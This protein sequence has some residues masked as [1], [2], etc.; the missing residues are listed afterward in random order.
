MKYYRLLKLIGNGFRLALFALAAIGAVL[1]IKWPS[2]I[3]SINKYNDKIIKLYEKTHRTSFLKASELQQDRPLAAIE[4]YES[5]LKEVALVD[6]GDRLY[7][8]KRKALRNL[9]SLLNAT[10]QPEKALYWARLWVE[11]DDLDIYAQVQLGQALHKT[12]ETKAQ[13]VQLLASLF[14]RFPESKLI[15]EAYASILLD[16]RETAAAFDVLI[17][18]HRLQTA[19]NFI[20]FGWEV[21]WGFGDGFVAAN[22]KQVWA[23][24]STSTSAVVTFKMN[25]PIQATEYRVD[26]PASMGIVILNPSL[27][28]Y[29]NHQQ[30][31]STAIW[32]QSLVLKQMVLNNNA[33][34]AD[35]GA[36][37]FF[38]WELPADFR[39]TGDQLVFKAELQHL[40]SDI[41][42]KLLASEQG[43]DIEQN[44]L[45]S[46]DSKTLALLRDLRTQGASGDQANQ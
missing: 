17:K 45:H 16:D 34:I 2:S 37:P 31:R 22:R 42:V 13:A 4:A 15:A 7:P 12:K 46:G 23:K 29:R 11:M 28:V 19:Q 33:L 9:L 10:K 6:K 5:F 8:L 38:A 1:L 27:Q 35:G 32:E 26:V 30:I 43:A 25:V 39:T 14:Q 36:D 21:F 24:I 18:N 41:L 20:R 3:Q 40:P 44:L